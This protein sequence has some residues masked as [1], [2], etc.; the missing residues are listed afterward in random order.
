VEAGVPA[1]VALAATHQRSL[2]VVPL[3]MLQAHAAG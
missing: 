2:E 3:A 1:P